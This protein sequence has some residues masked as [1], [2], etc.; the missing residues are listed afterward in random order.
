MRAGRA[1]VAFDSTVTAP[2]EFVRELTRL[3]GFTAKI[4]GGPPAEAQTAGS[5]GEAEPRP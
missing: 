3:T 1:V 2:A 4:V 5:D